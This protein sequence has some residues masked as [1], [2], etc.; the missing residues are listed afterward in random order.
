MPL[1][2]L[3][4]IKAGL[5]LGKEALSG[6]MPKLERIIHEAR[7]EG[8]FLRVQPRDATPT[9][10]VRETSGLRGHD[11]S[12]TVSDEQV[13]AFAKDPNNHVKQ[14]A[15]AYTNN[16]LQKPYALP[17]MPES[18]LAKQSAIGRT[19][20]HATTEDPAYKTAVFDA[21]KKQMPD[22][23]EQHNIKDYDDLVNKSYSQ[24][25]KETEDQFS[26]LPVNMSFHQNGEGNYHSSNEMLKDVIGNNER[27]THQ[28]AGKII[29]KGS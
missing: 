12:P 28:K 2:T 5:Q 15:N 23:I 16:T 6:T 3:P 10:G 11:V 27:N 7:Q 13:K 4:E 29:G 20:L 21:Y 26:T 25:A 9:R 22:L 24:L 1:L 14:R 18:S 8:P 19:F 17:N